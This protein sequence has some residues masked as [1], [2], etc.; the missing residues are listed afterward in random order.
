MFAYVCVGGWV[1][2]PFCI[3]SVLDTSDGSLLCVCGDPLS[4]GLSVGV[5]V[6]VP[7]KCMA[8]EICIVCPPLSVCVCDWRLDVCASPACARG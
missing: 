3:V 7:A 2:G 8:V 4:L 5:G 1:H 6:R